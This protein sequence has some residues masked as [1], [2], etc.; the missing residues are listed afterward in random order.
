M[1]IGLDSFAAIDIAK[2]VPTSQEWVR[3]LDELIDR[4][5]FADAV[6]M[7][8]FGIGEHH[9]EEFLDSELDCK[10]SYIKLRTEF[11]FCFGS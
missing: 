2:G 4:I 1:E 11:L 5:A 10:R 7:D 8:F 6:G 3:A 9:R